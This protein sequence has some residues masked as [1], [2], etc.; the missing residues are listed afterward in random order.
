LRISSR[1]SL[2][3]VSTETALGSVPCRI[4]Y[5]KSA[6][7]QRASYERSSRKTERLWYRLVTTTTTCL[8]IRLSGRPTSARLHIDK[9]HGEPQTR[10]RGQRVRV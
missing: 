6:R 1:C 2:Y 4:K 3:G 7:I 9:V 5:W 10:N 8:L